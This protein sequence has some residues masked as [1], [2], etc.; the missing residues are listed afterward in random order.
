M[1]SA[2]SQ[3]PLSFIICRRSGLANAVQDWADRSRMQINTEKTE[4]MAFF[5]TPAMKAARTSATFVVTFRFPASKPPSHIQLKEPPTFT[6]LGLQ[7]DPILSM[8]AAA[9]HMV[10]KINWA[11]RRGR[12][13]SSPRYTTA[14]A[15]LPFLPPTPVPVV[16]IMRAPFCHHQP[17]ISHQ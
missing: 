12:P 11:H 8:F 5:E 7:L 13:Q 10:R 3:G 14:P 6:Y 16:A 9:N 1:F 15:T 2:P 4:V 17:A